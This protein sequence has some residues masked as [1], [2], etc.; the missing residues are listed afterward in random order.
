MRKANQENISH[1]T[2][3]KGRRWSVCPEN[4][5]QQRRRLS[6]RNNR[7]GPRTYASAAS[8]GTG[9]EAASSRRLSEKWNPARPP[10]PPSVPPTP[11]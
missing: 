11:L 9:R 10:H 2:R 6:A 8:P 3:K 1:T 5:Q 7:P 4:G